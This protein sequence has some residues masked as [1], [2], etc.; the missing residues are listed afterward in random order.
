MRS[1]HK[2]TLGAALVLMAG[3]A[4]GFTTTVGGEDEVIKLSDAP[5]AVQ[6]TIREH[7]QGG[8]IEKIERSTEHGKTVY[9]VEVD[10]RSGDFEFVVGS[11]GTYLGAD[12]ED[13][14]EDDEQGERNERG[15]QPD[16]NDSE[17][18]TVIDFSAA[19]A[20]IRQA[21]SSHSGNANATKVERI[22]EEGVTKYEIEYSLPA[23]TASMTFAATGEVMEVESPVTLDALPEAVRREVLHDY[24]G[25][26][27]T[28]AE[29]VQ[30]FYYE[31]DV[32]V[33]GKT[34][35]VAAFATGDIEDRLLGDEGSEGEDAGHAKKGR[36]SDE[37]DEDGEED[38]D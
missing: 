29:G 27:I 18:V 33:N 15:E 8:T 23:G 36:D 6:K 30:L 24:P 14:D 10:G 35:E 11:D 16:E 4:I 3:A 13:E 7:A 28:A 22:E 1:S 19:P 20:A 26:R 31:M 2:A 32:E 12:T 37:D 34:I 9:E 38:D 17:D 5:A 21:F 25:A